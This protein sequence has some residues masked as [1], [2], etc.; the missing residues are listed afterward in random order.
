MIGHD[1]AMRYFFFGSLRDPDVLTAVLGRRPLP[2]RIQPAWLRGFRLLHMRGETYPL[3]AAAPA[4]VVRGALVH[5]LTEADAARLA[6]FEGEE[7]ETTPV[8][9]R[10]GARRRVRALVFQ[11]RPELAGGGRPWDFAAW[12]RAHK[13]AFLP[14]ARAWMAFHGHADFAQVEAMWRKRRIH[15]FGAALS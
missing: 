7:Y 4:G 3:L 14:L 12:R 11:A 13:R 6:F 2:A 10:I 9:A 15:G 5:G 1:H 8:M